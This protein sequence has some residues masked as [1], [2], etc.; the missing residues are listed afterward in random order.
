MDQIKWTHFN[1][2][3]CLGTSVS[4]YVR[5]EKGLTALKSRRHTD[6]HAYQNLNLGATVSLKRFLQK[7]SELCEHIIRHSRVP[8]SHL[9]IGDCI[10]VIQPFD[11][12]KTGRF[13]K[14]SP[15]LSCFYT[16]TFLCT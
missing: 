2:G 15:F 14:I 11:F 10:R 9:V 8:S 7:F 5:L 6:T 4:C 13:W 12:A 3:N 16:F 1:K